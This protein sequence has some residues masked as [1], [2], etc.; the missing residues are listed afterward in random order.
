[1]VTGFRPVRLVLVAAVLV[2]AGYG[3]ASSAVATVRELVLLGKAAVADSNLAAES[4]Q[5][6]PVYALGAPYPDIEFLRQQLPAGSLYRLVMP[7]EDM[8][9]P[10]TRLSTGHAVLYYLYPSVAVDDPAG[11]SILIG[12]DGADLVAAG[13]KASSIIG[14]GKV[15]L[16]RT[17]AP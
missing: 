12:V 4:K 14:R 13:A 10:V 7:P 5:A 9:V 15:M 11:V 3:L 1:M 2:V 8:A 6:S 16:G 17:A